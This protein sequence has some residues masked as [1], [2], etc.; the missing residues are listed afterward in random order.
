MYSGLR[1]SLD[2]VDENHMTEDFCLLTVAIML[3]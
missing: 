3:E 1:L 2:F